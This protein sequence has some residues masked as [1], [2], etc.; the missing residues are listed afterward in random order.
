LVKTA[1]GG[2]GITPF[3]DVY[4]QRIVRMAEFRKNAMSVALRGKRKFDGERP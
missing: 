3:T 1:A 2:Y 4:Y